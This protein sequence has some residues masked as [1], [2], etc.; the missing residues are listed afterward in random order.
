MFADENCVL[1]QNGHLFIKLVEDSVG[2]PPLEDELDEL[3]D[4]DDWVVFS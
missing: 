1:K 4:R 3:D 2:E